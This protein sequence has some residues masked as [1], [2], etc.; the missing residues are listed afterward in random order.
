MVDDENEVDGSAGRVAVASRRVRV[1]YRRA[2]DNR[3]YFSTRRAGAKHGTHNGNG[4]T[5]VCGW[6]KPRLADERLIHSFVRYLSAPGT[7]FGSV[8]RLPG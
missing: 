3:R 1:C 4:G 7:V 8:V 2:V 5:A 6:I